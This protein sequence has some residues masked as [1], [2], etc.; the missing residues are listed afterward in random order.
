M[1]IE[2]AIELLKAGRYNEIEYL[3]AKNMAVKALEEKLPE[4]KEETAEENKEETAENTVSVNEIYCSVQEVAEE[5]KLI[6]MLLNRGDCSKKCHRK[7]YTALKKLNYSELREFISDCKE[8]RK[9]IIE[10]D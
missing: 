8:I 5:I 6:G 10:G 7:F 2:K 3:E 1:T 4:S 9:M